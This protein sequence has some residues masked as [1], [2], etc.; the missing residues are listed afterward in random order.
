M[1]KKG[2]LPTAYFSLFGYIAYKEQGEN[3]G[4][5]VS[6]IDFGRVILSRGLFTVSKPRYIT[7]VK[8]YLSKPVILQNRNRAPLTNRKTLQKLV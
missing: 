6:T 4:T 7:A 3:R 8:P 5:M 2:P 1:V